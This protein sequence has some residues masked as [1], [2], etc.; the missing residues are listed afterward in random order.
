MKKA[1]SRQS[2]NPRGIVGAVV[3][4]KAVTATR[5]EPMAESSG[6]P[7][8]ASSPGTTRKPPPMPKKP[9][10]VPTPAHR[11]AAAAAA[12]APRPREADAGVA[13]GALAQQHQ[14]GDDDHQHAEQQQQLLPVER[15]A[16]WEPSAA[17][18]TPAAAKT[19]AQGQLTLPARACPQ[20]GG[21][22]DRHGDRARAD[23]DMRR[24]D[25]DDI[26]QQRHGQDRA[27]AADQAEDE[28]DERAGAGG[29]QVDDADH[30]ASSRPMALACMVSPSRDRARAGRAGGSEQVDRDLQEPLAAGVG[31]RKSPPRMLTWIDGMMSCGMPSVL[32]RAVRMA[33]NSS[34]VDAVAD[35]DVAAPLGS[36]TVVSQ[37]I[38]RPSGP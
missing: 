1:T 27:A 6:M 16:E 37:R 20:I 3:M 28:A 34:S 8:E 13:G 30:A 35:M 32:S 23:R 38:S 11:P 17:P 26:D 33:T 9:E 2:I 21:G 7:V 4:P 15:L 18:S 22:A 24:G 29:Q 19:S 31:G 5:D 14:G 36:A 25:A 12:A 10:S